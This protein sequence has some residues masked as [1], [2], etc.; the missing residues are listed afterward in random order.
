MTEFNVFDSSLIKR[1]LIF[2]AA[3]G[4]SIKR[5]LEPNSCRFRLASGDGFLL[6]LK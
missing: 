3:E 5:N 4:V 1:I 6:L 2:A